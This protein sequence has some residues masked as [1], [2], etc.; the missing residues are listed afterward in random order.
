MTP[1]ALEEA[2]AQDLLAAA[3][4]GLRNE[5][6]R[7]SVDECAAREQ[8]RARM[9]VEAIQINRANAKSYRAEI[10]ENCRRIRAAIAQAEGR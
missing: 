1:R 3:K 8:D 5:I 4:L 7:T 9:T 10:Q 6:L 2:E